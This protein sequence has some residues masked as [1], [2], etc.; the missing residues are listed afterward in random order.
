[1]NYNNREYL[2]TT[3]KRIKILEEPIHDIDVY[4]KTKPVVE[5][6]P[7]HFGKDKYRNEHEAEYRNVSW[8]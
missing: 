5:V 3:E 2:K 1:M 4:R 8:T 6:I 7:K